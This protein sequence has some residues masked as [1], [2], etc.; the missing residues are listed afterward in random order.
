MSRYFRRDQQEE[1]SKKE[2]IGGFRGHCVAEHLHLAW[3][4]A[5]HVISK[6]DQQQ[7]KS[8]EKKLAVSEVAALL[9]KVAGICYLLVC[10]CVSVFGRARGKI[11]KEKKKNSQADGARAAYLDFVMR[12]VALSTLLNVTLTD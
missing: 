12:S 7:E 8:E 2:K 9:S 1:K 5:C 4:C 6:R 10:V 11:G 3:V